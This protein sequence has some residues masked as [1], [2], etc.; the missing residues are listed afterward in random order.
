LLE[1]KNVS[2]RIAEKEDLPLLLEWWNTPEFYGIYK[3]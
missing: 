2:L 1:G 3:H